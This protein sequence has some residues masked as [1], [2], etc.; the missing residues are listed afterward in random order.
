[1]IRME[2]EFENSMKLCVKQEGELETLNMLLENETAK[3]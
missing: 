2:E 3:N 1:M